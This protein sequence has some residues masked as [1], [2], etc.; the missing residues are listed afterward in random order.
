MSPHWLFAC[1]TL[2]LL[3]GSKAAEFHLINQK[4]VIQSPAVN[5][6]SGL[7]VSPKDDRFLWTL[8]DSGGKPELYLLNT[9]GTDRG[10]VKV[11]NTSNVDWEDIASFTLD[12]KSYLLIADTGDNK[13][14]RKSCT[15][16][17]LRE[18][19]LPADGQK[20]EG[21]VATEWHVDFTYD[22]GPRDCE[23]VA[24]VRGKIIL[25]SKR[26]QPPEVYE[27][28]LRAPAKKG[29]LV[30]SPIGKTSVESPA[31]TL[32][33]FGNQPVGMNISEDETIA[34]VVTYYGVFLFPRKPEESWADAFSHK[35]TPL[36][37]HSLAQAE[38]VAF[39]KD[40]KSIYV[41]SEGRNSPIATYQ[42]SPG[43]P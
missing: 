16:H 33:P 39:S 20:L 7:A 40:G 22:G 24:V 23:S 2:G 36:G 30:L 4:H 18:P 29:A 25:I 42:S 32:I 21:T 34:A 38:S 6:A 15:L 13:A 26:T 43:A 14:V 9:D 31:G 41:V 35:P 19:A 12:G 27:L 10:K 17:I 5:E 3:S 37:P 11:A 8:N 28:P 1:F